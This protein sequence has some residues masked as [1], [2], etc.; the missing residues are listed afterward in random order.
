L[1]IV[2]LLIIY[3][4]IFALETK[5]LTLIAVS[6]PLNI[7]IMITMSPNERF[8]IL[9]A[10]LTRIDFVTNMLK[11]INEECNLKKLYSAELDSLNSLYRKLSN[12]A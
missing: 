10:L 3:F 5:R 9:S 1:F 11:S 4:I 12:P 8:I 7:F 6:S 2:M